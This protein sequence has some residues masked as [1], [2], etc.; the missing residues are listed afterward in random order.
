MIYRLMRIYNIVGYKTN[1]EAL[2][3]DFNKLAAEDCL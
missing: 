1:G 3:E 2:G